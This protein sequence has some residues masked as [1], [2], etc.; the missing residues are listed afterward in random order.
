MP[1]SPHS[2]GTPVV[3]GPKDWT[4]RTGPQAEATS[5]AQA[6]A[7]VEENPTGASVV[8]TMTL[9]FAIGATDVARAQRRG[10][11]G[12]PPRFGQGTELGKAAKVEQRVDHGLSQL[13]PREQAIDG[14][15]IEWADRP[16]GQS[17][18]IQCRSAHARRFME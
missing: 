6:E 16:Q 1:R 8:S 17:A 4:T 9:A 18:R 10:R 12:A 11:P 15:M 3:H 7:T 2:M 5:I 13:V 14:K